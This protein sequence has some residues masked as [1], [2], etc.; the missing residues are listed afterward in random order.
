MLEF[1]YSLFWYYTL[2]LVFKRFYHILYFFYMHYI[3]SP[4][5]IKER[6]EEKSWVLVTGATDGIGKGLA[7]EFAKLNFNIILVSR[8]QSKLETVAEE[9]KK[10]TSNNIQ[11]KIVPFDFSVKTK[12]SD[13]IEA[14]S[15]VKNLNL[16][17]LV[18][19]VGWTNPGRFHKRPGKELQDEVNLNVLPQ[20]LLTTM[21]AKNLS[22]RSGYMS[23]IINLSS[24][25]SGISLVG[26]GMYTAGKAFN[27]HHSK[28][29]YYELNKSMD[30]ISIKP[31][32]V[33]TPL[34]QQK[35]NWLNVITV[36]QL[37]NSILKQLGHEISTYG[38]PRHDW[39]A[40]LAHYILPGRNLLGKAIKYVSN[41][42]Y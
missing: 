3:R 4:Y 20:A 6:Y 15:F 13:Y 10:I 14:F 21:F 19:N 38:H 40:S 12:V 35:A 22:T 27:N 8:T 2:Y 41:L 29:C 39:Q 7:I 9:I 24:F 32:Y 17:V 36:D 37:N 1:I 26:F 31:M 23:L 5:N 28:A 30:V 18:N 33:E 42:E 34:S 25:A 16:S 11:I